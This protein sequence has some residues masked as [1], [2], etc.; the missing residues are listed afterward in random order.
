MISWRSDILQ[1]VKVW[2]IN[3]DGVALHS[4]EPWTLIIRCYETWWLNWFMHI[5]NSSLPFAVVWGTDF[6]QGLLLKIILYT[7]VNMHTAHLHN[8]IL[9]ILTLWRTQHGFCHIF[10][11]HIIFSWALEKYSNSK[12]NCYVKVSLLR[13]LY[14][15]IQYMY[16]IS[17]TP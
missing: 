10:S 5:S 2:H 16:G 7:G 15:N 13:I 9:V 3:C 12:Q 6:R 17:I 8:Y 14:I 4:C 1:L 11:I